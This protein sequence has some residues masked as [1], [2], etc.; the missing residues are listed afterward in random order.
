MD[1]SRLCEIE[2]PCTPEEKAEW[3][4]LC[5][6]HHLTMDDFMQLA[7]HHLIVRHEIRESYPDLSDD[8]LEDEAARI[9]ECFLWPE[10]CG[11][12]GY[13]EKDFREP[14][15]RIA[16]R[17]MEVLAK[18]QPAGVWPISKIISL[19]RLA[20]APDLA[21]VDPVS[22]LLSATAALV[23]KWRSLAPARRRH[24][25]TEFVDRLTMLMDEAEAYARPH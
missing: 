22:E 1:S 25:L 7:V 2:V 24:R 19:H 15:Y 8:D 20:M 9:G 6:R 16:A 4:A 18:G 5:E 17:T 11:S 13:A 14:W 3:E 23:P 21:V 10:V 12:P